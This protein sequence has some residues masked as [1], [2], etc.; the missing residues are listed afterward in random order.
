[1]GSLWG[2]GAEAKT[3]LE[4][5]EFCAHFSAWLYCKAVLKSTRLTLKKAFKKRPKNGKILVLFCDLGGGRNTMQNIDEQKE[6]IVRTRL[7]LGT[8]SGG[9]LRT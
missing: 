5:V 9:Q 3:A 4:S 1:M 7:P 6:V 2:P 8:R